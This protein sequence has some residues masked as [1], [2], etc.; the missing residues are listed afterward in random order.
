MLADYFGM[1][2]VVSWKKEPPNSANLLRKNYPCN[3]IV[4]NKTRWAWNAVTKQPHAGDRKV[5]L[6]PQLIKITLILFYTIK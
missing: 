4:S 3:H 2:V 1:K 6:A 5:F